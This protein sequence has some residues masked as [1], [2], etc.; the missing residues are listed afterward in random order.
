MEILPMR[1]GEDGDWEAEVRWNRARLKDCGYVPYDVAR[2]W[3]RRF[4]MLALVVIALIA[5]ILAA[6]R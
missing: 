4:W 2:Q 5:V 6:G 3:R 1:W